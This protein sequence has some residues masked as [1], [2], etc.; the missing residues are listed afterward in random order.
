MCAYVFRSGAP[1][2][3]ELFTRCV[4]MHASSAKLLRPACVYNSNFAFDRW[5]FPDVKIER[6][7]FFGCSIQK[8]AHRGKGEVRLSNYCF[9]YDASPCVPPSPQFQ[10]CGEV[11]CARI[12]WFLQLWK[13]RVQ[14]TLKLGGT[15]GSHSRIGDGRFF[16]KPREPENW[17]ENYFKEGDGYERSLWAPLRGITLRAIRSLWDSGRGLWG[18]IFLWVFVCFYLSAY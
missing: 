12:G 3:C 4:F 5:R 9:I 17:V 8:N 2:P 11:C 7:M 18:Q 6:L 15:G 14:A 10:C 16:R 13:V 1:R